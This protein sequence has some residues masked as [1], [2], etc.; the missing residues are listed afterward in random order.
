M[1]LALAAAVCYALG[2]VMQQHAASEVPADRLLL[3]LADLLERDQQAQSKV[4]AALDPTAIK[5]IQT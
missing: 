5:G 1:L 3:R 2:G 4:T